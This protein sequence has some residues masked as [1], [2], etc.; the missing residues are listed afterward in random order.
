[1]CFDHILPLSQVLLDPFSLKA[2][3][4]LIVP[5]WSVEQSWLF[6]YFIKNSNSCKQ[7]TK[8]RKM[9]HTSNN[10]AQRVEL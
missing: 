5:Q 1:M 4:Q 2:R 6:L 8:D 10:H 9:H 7:K 3:A